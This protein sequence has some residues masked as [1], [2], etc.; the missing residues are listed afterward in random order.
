ML[1]AMTREV[2]AQHAIDPQRVYVAGLSAGGAMAAIL[3]SAYPDLYAAVGVHSGLAAGAAT[4]LPGALAAM[5]GGPRRPPPRRP[6]RAHH[7]LSWRCR[8][9]RAPGEWRAGHCCLRGHGVIRGNPSGARWQRARL[10]EAGPRRCGRWPRGRRALGGSWLAPRLVGRQ[11][12][13]LLH[14]QPWPGRHRRDAAI[15][16]RAS[17]AAQAIKLRSAP[18][19]HRPS[20][21]A[22][23][24]RVRSIRCQPAL[25]ACLASSQ[26]RRESP[27]MVSQSLR[28]AGSYCSKVPPSYLARLTHPMR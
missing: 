17:A 15:L 2:M 23:P 20:P 25:T 1:A 19:H 8:S 7:R 27:L 11:P 10:H 4:D 22:S 9:D 13:R 5:R 3:G 26:S 16:L 24:G 14:R 21:S 28:N 6:W 18:A 12:A